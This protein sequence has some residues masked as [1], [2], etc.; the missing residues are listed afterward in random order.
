[1]FLAENKAF[2]ALESKAAE[3]AGASGSL[4]VF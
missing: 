3:G 2:V 1:M 4:V